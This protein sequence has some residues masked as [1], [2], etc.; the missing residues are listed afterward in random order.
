MGAPY[1][2]GVFKFCSRCSLF[3][4]V[5]DFIHAEVHPRA[6]HIHTGEVMREVHAAV[7]INAEKFSGR[8]RILIRREELEVPLVRGLLVFDAILHVLRRVFAAGVLQAICDDNAENVL[9]TLRF[10]HVGELATNGVDG[11]TNR[12]IKSGTARAFV[13]SH[14]VVVELHEYVRKMF[15]DLLVVPVVPVVMTD[16]AD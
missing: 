14:E 4:G 9:G 2:G 8:K 16:T 6:Q 15:F 3:L 13:A 7:V 11:D 1:L 5:A 12:I 10:F